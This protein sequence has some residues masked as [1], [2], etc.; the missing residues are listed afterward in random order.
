MHLSMEIIMNTENSNEIQKKAEEKNSNTR[1]LIV[2][3][4][5][6]LMLIGLVMYEIYSRK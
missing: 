4:F 6:V 5:F 2:S 1:A 3:G